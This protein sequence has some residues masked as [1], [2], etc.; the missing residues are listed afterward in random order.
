MV[1]FNTEK[2]SIYSSINTEKSFNYCV[3]IKKIAFARARAIL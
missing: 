2:L 3:K 1:A